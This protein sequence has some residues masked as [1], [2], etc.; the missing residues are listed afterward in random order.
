METPNERIVRC[1]GVVMR[2]GDLLMVQHINH[3][4]GREYWWLPGGGIHA[5][6]T[7]EACVVRE[8]KEETQ[9]DVAVERLLFESF[10]PARRQMYQ[11]YATFLCRPI[12]GSVG[13]GHEAESSAIHSII[14]VAW[15][16]LWDEREW[17]A[18]FYKEHLYPLLK[19][20][21]NALTQK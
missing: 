10:D 12:G 17:Q 21:Q 18:D 11:A 16:A 8:I 5:G 19:Q 3:R 13:I 20:I 15:F 9:L 4:T 1:Q 2:E 14:G 6:E 7:R